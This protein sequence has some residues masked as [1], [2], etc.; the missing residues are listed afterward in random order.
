MVLI[1]VGSVT[2]TSVIAPAIRLVPSEQNCTKNSSPTRPY[3][4][5]GIPARVSVASSI[6]LTS[7]LFLAYS[8][9][10]I[11]APTPKGSTIISVNRM[12]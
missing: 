3:I 1:I 8:L 2:I 12:I 4:I 6:I 11:A 10:Y 5:E 7:F 9:R